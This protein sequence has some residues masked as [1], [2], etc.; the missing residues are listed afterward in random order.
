M[1]WLWHK[2]GVSPGWRGDRWLP[3][4]DGPRIRQLLSQLQQPPDQC[5]TWGRGE[6]GSGRGRVLDFYQK[7]FPR[8]CSWRRD[9]S[10]RISQRC[11]S[12]AV[13]LHSC[14]PETAPASCGRGGIGLKIQIQHLRIKCLINI[15]K[16]SVTRVSME[17]GFNLFVSFTKG[18]HCSSSLKLSNTFKSAF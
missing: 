4:R 7:H 3:G 8:Y 15:H 16:E 11:I 13:N 1:L 9:R 10:C 2:D 17:I 18:F 5:K 6:S 14:R 12:P